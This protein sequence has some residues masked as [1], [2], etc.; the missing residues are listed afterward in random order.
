LDE[1]GEEG[2]GE[3]AAGGV[4]AEL[5]FP[6]AVCAK[7]VETRM[8][9]TNPASSIL[10]ESGTKSLNITWVSYLFLVTVLNVR[11]TAS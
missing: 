7:P 5:P 3:E 1:A 6:W 9:L 4:T 2:A 10:F 11:F 8:P